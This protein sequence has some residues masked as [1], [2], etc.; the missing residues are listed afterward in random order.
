VQWFTGATQREYGRG[1]RIAALL[2]GQVLFLIAYPAFVVWGASFLDRWLGLPRFV[3]ALLNPIVAALLLAPGLLLAEWTVGLQFSQGLGT[4]L[5]VV[6]TRRLITTG[7]YDY[8][9]NPMATGT[10]MVYTGIAVCMGSLSAVVLA[11]IYPLAIILYTKLV[12]EKELERRFGSEYVAY[13]RRTP[14]L[15][16]RWP[17]SD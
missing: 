1:R 7:P 8:S 16:P 2:L 10:T 3:H 6:A 14:F 17:G 12:E 13:K 4:P 11:S 9:R 5:P 15:I